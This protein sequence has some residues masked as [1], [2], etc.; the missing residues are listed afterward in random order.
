VTCAS[1]SARA[2]ELLHSERVELSWVPP[3]LAVATVSDWESVLESRPRALLLLA[4]PEETLPE[5]I[6]AAPIPWD[7]AWLPLRREELRLR[8]QWLL[9]ASTRRLQRILPARDGEERLALVGRITTS[10]AQQMGNALSYTCTNVEYLRDSIHLGGARDPELPMVATESREGIRRALETCRALL[11][12]A[13]SSSVELTRVNVNETIQ[14]TLRLLTSAIPRGIRLEA[15]LETVPDAFGD[16]SGLMQV[17]ATLI[18]DAA[19]AAG[20]GGQVRVRTEHL[21][22]GVIVS[23]A[24]TRPAIPSALGPALFQADA[25]SM[26]AES[27]GGKLEIATAGLG[28]A[29]VRVLLQA[30]QGMPQD[31]VR[32]LEVS[33]T[34]S[35]RHLV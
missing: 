31:F 13:S 23:V 19:E 27:F 9:R 1:V 22:A 16:A 15:Q 28:G 26:L 7:V 29:E 30:A 18:L 2:A 25:L 6:E 32:P 34:G 24:D 3:T 17:L 33:D 11:Q 20:A 5:G 35:R 8:M 21:K 10:A 4:Q 12:L 14:Q